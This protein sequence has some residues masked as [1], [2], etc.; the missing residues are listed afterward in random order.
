L[1]TDAGE[2]GAG[3]IVMNAA[4]D[5]L[6]VTNRG[7]DSVAVIAVDGTTLTPI[8]HV[9]SGGASPRFLLLLEEQRKLLVAN[10]EGGSIRLFAIADD[11]RLSCRDTVNIP[12]AAF[13]AP[14]K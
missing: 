1:P 8:E 12:S 2:S 11:G 3:A 6:Y 10:E 5:R 7:H 4:R 9:P 14:L 13:V